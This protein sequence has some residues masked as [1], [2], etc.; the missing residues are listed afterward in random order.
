MIAFDVVRGASLVGL[1][2]QG[3]S[4]RW[5]SGVVVENFEL[6]TFEDSFEDPKAPEKAGLP[7]PSHR[8]SQ[9]LRC[10]VVGQGG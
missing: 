1:L 7:P 8:G 9:F 4:V 3:E 6:E 10:S 5:D 2:L